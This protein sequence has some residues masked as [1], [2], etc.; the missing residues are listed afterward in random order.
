MERTAATPLNAHGPGAAIGAGVALFVWFTQAELPP[1]IEAAIALL[2]AKTV[3]YFGS[4]F[5]SV[6]AD[7]PDHWLRHFFR[8]RRVPIVLL[9]LL[10][11]A[12]AQAGLRGGTSL[13]VFDAGGYADGT[14]TEKGGASIY[15]EGAGS[16]SIPNPEDPTLPPWV[17]TFDQG[18]RLEVCIGPC[19]RATAQDQDALG[20]AIE[21]LA[22]KIPDPPPVVP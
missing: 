1:G 12:C 7:N 20:S 14:A 10:P 2:A 11:L 16:L 9:L 3:D 5:R 15:A 8:A 13:D 21:T 19:L 22:D 6:V 4:V 17:F 18:G